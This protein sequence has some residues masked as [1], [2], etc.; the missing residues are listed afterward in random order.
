MNDYSSYT[1]EMFQWLQF[2]LI[3]EVNIKLDAVKLDAVITYVMTYIQPSLH[4]LFKLKKKKKS[5]LFQKNHRDFPVVENILNVT[6]ALKLK[7][8]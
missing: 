8:T 5:S 6:E 1:T 7:T 2:L 4:F 3:K